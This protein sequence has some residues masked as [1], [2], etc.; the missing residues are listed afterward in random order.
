MRRLDIVD[1]AAPLPAFPRVP[2]T[3]A[4]PGSRPRTAPATRPRPEFGSLATYVWQ[5]EPDARS[6]PIVLDQASLMQLSGSA[7]SKAMSK[8]LRRR[9]W[10]FVGPTTVYAFM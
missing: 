10:L 4:C 6:P 1:A 3:L 7:Q 5:F 8:D 9:G 2:T